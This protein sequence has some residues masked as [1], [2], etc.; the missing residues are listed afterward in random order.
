[1]MPIRRVACIIYSFTVISCAMCIWG[2][3][4]VT[5]AGER[6]SAVSLICDAVA[7]VCGMFNIWMMEAWRKNG[8][9]E[10]PKDQ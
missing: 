7:I 8:W 2:A 9:L 3:L 10:K 6:L 5:C 1:M 4:T